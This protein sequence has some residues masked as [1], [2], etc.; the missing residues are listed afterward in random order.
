MLAASAIT[1]YWFKRNLAKE[2]FTAPHIRQLAEG[3][4][5]LDQVNTISDDGNKKKVNVYTTRKGFS[6]SCSNGSLSGQKKHFTISVKNKKTLN[7]P[8]AEKMAV[9]IATLKKYAETF[10]LVEKQNGIFHILFDE[11]LNETFMQ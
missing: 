2:L 9:T 7:R 3:L 6:V 5:M 4:N 11:P 8:A 10:E 1:I